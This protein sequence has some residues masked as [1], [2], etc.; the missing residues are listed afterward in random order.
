MSRDPSSKDEL[1]FK[2]EYPTRIRVS[3]YLFPIGML[4][5]VFFIW[6]MIISASI[7]P[8]L[9]FALIFGVTSMSMPLILFREVRFGE[10]IVVRR[11]YLPK[12]VIRY[13]DVVELTARGLRAKHGGI[14][15][16]NVQ[17]RKEFEKIFHQLVR[18]K[19]IVLE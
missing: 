17:N 7:F 19:K 2:P 3:V 13:T 9:I 8:N 12:L 4:A 10:V 5:C 6:S 1:V 15:L 16:A 11:Y 14:P 18:Q